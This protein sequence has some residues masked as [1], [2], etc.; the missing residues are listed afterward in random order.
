M[1]RIPGML[2]ALQGARSREGRL[3]LSKSRNA[4]FLEVSHSLIASTTKSACPSTCS[5]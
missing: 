4:A 1:I 2:G 3:T 5:K